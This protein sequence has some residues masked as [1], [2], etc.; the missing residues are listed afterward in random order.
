VPSALPSILDPSDVITSSSIQSRGECQRTKSSITAPGLAACYQPKRFKNHSSW[1][2][3]YFTSCI[4]KRGELVAFLYLLH[5]LNDSQVGDLCILIRMRYEFRTVTRQR[6]LRSWRKA[7]SLLETRTF[8]AKN[9][10]S[11]DGCKFA[12]L[13]GATKRQKEQG[14]RPIDKPDTLV[15]KDWL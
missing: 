12:S 10:I 13:K 14:Q 11:F 7:A 2:H 5:Q 9:G 1:K 15:S 4:L 6:H 3:N 8:G